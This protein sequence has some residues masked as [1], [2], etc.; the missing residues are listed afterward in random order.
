MPKPGLRKTRATRQR[1]DCLKS[2]SEW[3]YSPTRRE[4]I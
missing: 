4:G 2:S 3:V 1:L